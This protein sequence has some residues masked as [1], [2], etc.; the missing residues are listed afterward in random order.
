MKEVR[1]TAA[2]MFAYSPRPGT[3]AENMTDTVAPE[4]SQRR[5][6]DLIDLQTGITKQHYAAMLGRTVELLITE[7]QA[8]HDR[9]WMGQDR[10][11]KRALVACD[12]DVAGMILKVR[13]VDTTGMTLLCERMT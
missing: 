1:F 11:A 8:K 3:G 12:S 4:V 2:F 6:R 5:L 10:G 7:R 9:R 13:V